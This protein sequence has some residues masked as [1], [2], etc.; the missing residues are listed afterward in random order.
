MA[1]SMILMARLYLLR[2]KKRELSEEDLDGVSGEM[3]SSLYITSYSCF[4]FEN[5]YIKKNTQLPSLSPLED[6]DLSANVM[7]AG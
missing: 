3:G 4:N 6:N 2:G 5:T 7:T 1:I